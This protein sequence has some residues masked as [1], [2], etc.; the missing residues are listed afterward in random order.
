[1]KLYTQPVKRVKF[2]FFSLR[3]HTSYQ[4]V[5]KCYEIFSDD[6]LT[7]FEK[8]D[9]CLSLLVRAKIVLWF[10][11]PQ[12]KLHLFH[13]IFKEFID[14]PGKKKESVE[15]LFDFNQDAGF[16]YSSFWQCYHIDLIKKDKNLHWWSFISLFNGLSDD[17]KMMQILSI[18]S[19]P[20][21]KPTKYNQEE[22]RQLIRLKQLYR[23]GISEEERKEQFQKGLEKIASTLY[24]LAERS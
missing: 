20:L 24:R 13:K 4:A 17:T 22:R 7:E 6:I 5:L 1:M 15:K 3:L 14:I 19:R 21:P 16:I 18:R 23:L 12:Q 9:A 2:G 11:S 10:L 8:I